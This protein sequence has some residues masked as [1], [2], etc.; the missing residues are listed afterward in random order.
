[1]HERPGD[2]WSLE[3]LAQAA[4][5]SRSAFAAQFRAALGMPP[6]EYLLHW[7]VSVAQTWLRAGRPVQ[8][9]SDALGYAS[10]AAFSRAFA[11]VAGAS[12]RQWLQQP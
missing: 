3:R 11:Q 7:R 6:G 12:P 9:I 5:M 1:M 8:Q 10:P 4:G 2:T